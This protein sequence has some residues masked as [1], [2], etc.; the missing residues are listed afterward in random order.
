MTT[1]QESPFYQPYAPPV[2]MIVEE[3]GLELDLSSS[4]LIL[5]NSLRIEYRL[6]EAGTENQI[7]LLQ[8]GCASYLHRDGRLELLPHAKE[9]IRQACESFCR[10]DGSRFVV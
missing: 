2:L 10:G 8:V 7:M 1:I 4:P 3:I 6:R 5:G 9:R